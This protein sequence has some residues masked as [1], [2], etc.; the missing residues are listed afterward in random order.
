M[1]IIG[2]HHIYYSIHIYHLYDKYK[3]IIAILC[4]FCS[5][6]ANFVQIMR[7]VRICSDF[8]YCANFVRIV[9]IVQSVRK[10]V[11]IF[12]HKKNIT[13]NKALCGSFV[14]IFCSFYKNRIEQPCLR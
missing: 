12:T 11:L 8:V 2:T 3:L 14:R 13:K 6:C 7:T 10:A 5:D 9:Q 4:E 1:N